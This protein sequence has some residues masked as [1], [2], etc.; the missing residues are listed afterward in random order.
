MN[1]KWYIKCNN[2]EDFEYS[3]V[4]LTDAEYAAV[5][6]FLDKSEY[7]SGGG[8]SGSCSISDVGYKTKEKAISEIMKYE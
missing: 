1:G 2:A 5:C 8:W 7:V 6:K 3:V 4:F